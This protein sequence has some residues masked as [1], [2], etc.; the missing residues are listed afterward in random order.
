MGISQPA[1]GLHPA[2]SGVYRKKFPFHLA[3]TSYIYADYMYDNASA[4]APYVDELELLLFESAN[5]PR[6]EE[7]SALA[8]LQNVTGLQYNVHLP[9]DI[10]L[11][12][13]FAHTRQEGINA[14]LQA[15]KLTKSLNPTTCTLHL[16]YPGPVQE[17]AEWVTACSGSLKSILAG[18]VEPGLISIETLNYPLKWIYEIIASF[19][20]SICLDFGHIL[21]MN[22]DPLVYAETYLDRTSIVH[23]HGIENGRDHQSLDILDRKVLL[24]WLKAL[25]SYK[26]VVSVE[27]FSFERLRSSLEALEEAWEEMGD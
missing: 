20:L 10:D 9:I 26:G 24:S 4:L 11:G 5:L 1:C 16:P 12:S 7:I 8:E 18:D 21:L 25:R 3:T 22:E 17:K 13:P 27:V 14:V 2:L 23:L 19:Q 6:P 15:I